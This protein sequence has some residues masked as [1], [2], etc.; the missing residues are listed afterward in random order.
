MRHSN[1]GQS[2]I[3]LQ[4]WPVESIAAG[5]ILDREVESNLMINKTKIAN[6]NKFNNTTNNLQKYGDIKH[7]CE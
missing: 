1:R 3:R 7:S 6:E 4:L 2:R 5:Q